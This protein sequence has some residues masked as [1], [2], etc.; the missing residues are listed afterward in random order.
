[1]P[2][3]PPASVVLDTNTVLDWLVFRDPAALS[4][5]AWIEAGRLDW[6][7]SPAMRQEF[8]HV[9]GRSALTRWTPDGP[10]AAATWDR[11]ARVAPAE[12]PAG[13]LRCLD[14]DDQVFID[15]ALAERCTWLVSRDRALL[16]LARRATPWGLTILTPQAW[17]NQ[18]S[19]SALTA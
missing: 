4:L 9:L 17:S 15:F 8:E 5:A 7:A 10:G 6:Q 14:P 16:R 3:A 1:M 2:S 19:M 13:P 18:N 11:L 12:P